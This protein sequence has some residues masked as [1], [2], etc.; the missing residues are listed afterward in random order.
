MPTRTHTSNT[1]VFSVVAPTITAIDT[2]GAAVLGGSGTLA[3]TVDGDVR[4]DIAVPRIGP[5]SLAAIPDRCQLNGTTVDGN[6]LKAEQAYPVGLSTNGTS[7]ASGLPVINVSFAP[8]EVHVTT[9][10]IDL[11]NWTKKILLLKGPHVF[12]PVTWTHGNLTCTLSPFTSP[13]SERER[14]DITAELT[15]ERTGTVANFDDIKKATSALLSL[16]S[17]THTRWV[18]ETTHCGALVG[19]WWAIPQP[20]DVA[21]GHPLISDDSLA[22]FMSQ[23]LGNYLTYT[24]DYSLETVLTYYCRSH[25]ENL[26]EAKFIFAGV[27]MEALKFYWALN[28]GRLP[29]DIKQTTGLIRGFK[30]PNGSNHTFEELMNMLAA[31]LGLAHTYSFVD[32]RNALFHSGRAA[33]AQLQQRATWAYLRPELE[34]VQDQ[35]DDILLTIL[36]YRG[37]FHRYWDAD[38]V[39]A[40]PGRAKIT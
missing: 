17:R 21:S 19:D 5:G 36:G 31:H 14:G 16:A 18:L 24:N 34:I 10:G 26:A 37:H 12:Q 27:A 1:S 3:V 28:V 20:G 35:L 38:T 6:N 39:Y 11:N 15:F 40:F 25:Q 7:P 8:A 4:V 33:A 30:R 13:R 32:D 9:P 23:T 2:G 22:S 29:Q